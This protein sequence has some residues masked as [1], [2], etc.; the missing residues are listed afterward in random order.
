LTI[1]AALAIAIIGVA[2][3]PHR[4]SGR[5]ATAQV[6]V[7]QS[8]A[9]G[10]NFRSRRALDP[11]PS[12][13]DRW[14]L[15]NA[16]FGDWLDA[17]IQVPDDSISE[18]PLVMSG[19]LR[20]RHEAL[21]SLIDALEKSVPKWPAPE[22]RN[23]PRQELVPMVSLARIFF[24]EALIQERAGN[25]IE[26]GRA[27]EASWSLLTAINSPPS[28]VGQLSAVRVE[29]W[30][31]GVLRK[32]KDPPLQWIDRL[33]GGRAWQ[34]MFDVIAQEYPASME[35]DPSSDALTRAL[36]RV[37]RATANRLR[38]QSPCDVSRLTDHQI[39]RSVAP[40][41]E[42]DPDAHVRANPDFIA[43]LLPTFTS[44]IRR[45]ARVAVEREFTARILALR[46]DVAASP[47]KI[48]PPR[49][50]DSASRVCPD[51]AYAYATDGHKMEIH[52]EGSIGAPDAIVLPLSFH[53]GGAP[54]P[55]S[56]PTP[57]PPLTES[58]SGGMIRLR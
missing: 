28:L 53:A 5:N 52:F 50:D 45:T 47:E 35:T 12:A 4:V 29:R 7:E 36:R 18:P 8:V 55:A 41:V 42:A 25:R 20:D 49:L 9:L 24:C 33:S 34:R 11:H 31:A 3:A 30:Q 40:E 2:G 17:Q 6:V 14:A 1:A 43:D 39:W 23:F 19:F 21:W 54:E 56:T 13:E 27:L 46:Q 38:K 16:G 26:A 32:M 57:L 48:P 15:A 37:Y 44:A 22:P 51:A 58:T 10:L